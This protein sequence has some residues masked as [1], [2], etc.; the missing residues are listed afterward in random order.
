[1][2]KLLIN[3]FIKDENSL[4]EAKRREK[5]CVLGGALGIVCNLLLFAIKLMAGTMMGSIAVVSDAFN[6]LSD[7]GSS[8]VSVIGSKLSG[9]KPDKDH[10]F[11][12]GRFEYISS[13]IVAFIIIIVGFELLKTSAAKIIEPERVS[14]SLPL[15]AVL[16]VSVFVKLWMYSYNRF[17]GKRVNSSLLFATARDSANDA[18][19]TSAVIA[20]TMIG[21]LVELPW[22][23]GVVGTL[24]SM[25]IL[26]SGF[27]VARGT[28]G[29]LL[30]APPEPETVL[31]IRRRIL[32]G[33]GI[34]GVHDLIVHD[35]GPGRVFASVHAEVPDT[36][37]IVRAH[38]IIDSLEHK[39]FSELGIETVIHTDP[40]SVNCE[41]CDRIKG[42]VLEIVRRIDGRMNIHDF[43][44]TDGEECINLIFDVE[45]PIDYSEREYLRERI[46]EGAKK[47][48]P[49]FRCVINLDTIY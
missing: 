33:E 46:A 44:M 2:I 36:A 5:Y 11:G 35:Y 10:P 7:C 12:H 27:D 43:R 15:T 31:E 39:I 20:T 22:L 41:R 25:M 34:V 19:S 9:K 1:M 6:N 21:G 3:I 17:L 42:E 14:F 32:E 16:C 47:L 37:D 38:E 18:I 28:V 40:I 29:L 8:V 48:D 45:V 13:L 26:Y 24:V 30:G 23:D 4:E 49:R